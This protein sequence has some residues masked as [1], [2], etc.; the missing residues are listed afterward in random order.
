MQKGAHWGCS[1]MIQ[2]PPFLRPQKV[3][4]FIAVALLVA[5]V[6]LAVIKPTLQTPPYSPP[7]DDSVVVLKA[8]MKSGELYVLS[9]TWRLV[10]A[11]DTLRGSG[12]HYSAT[13]V[14]ID[15]GMFTV[16]V[17]SI[18]V[19]ETNARGA[20]YPFGLQMLAAWT[21]LY[22]IVDVACLADPKSCFGSC[23][24][25]Y[26][27]ESH[28]STPR[29]EG[30]S[31][32]FARA[33]EAT[34]V[35]AL[36]EARPGASQVGITMR[37]EALET[38][39]VRA[40]RLRAALR[41]P[42]G[43]VLAT[44]DGRLYNVLAVA[45]PVACRASEGDCLSAVAAIDRRERLSVADST[46][47]AAKETVELVFPPS[48]GSLGVVI[49]ARNS[50]LSTYVFYQT[51]AY[52]GGRAGEWFARLERAGRRHGAA[53]ALG[54]ER[55][56]GGIEV[57][58]SQGD[59]AWR[60]IGTFHETGPIAGDLQVLPFRAGRADEPVHLRLRLARGNWRLDYVG[61]AH[62]G[63]A[64]TVATLE[65]AR[66]EEGGRENSAALAALLDPDRTLVTGPGDVY[67]LFFDLPSGRGE[68]ELFLESR[69]YYYEWMRKGWLKEENPAMVRLIL[70]KPHRALRQLARQYKAREQVMEDLFWRSRF[71]R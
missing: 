35:D 47:L 28:D 17:D 9:S 59:G 61:L 25:F 39:V 45:A 71:S 33:L 53:L 40:V 13:R 60:T 26:V 44:P 69:G 20:A 56:L 12:R 55:A 66:V 36:R 48:T 68:Y 52:M 49:A 15:S 51:L 3:V 54:I 29:A 7:P 65:P 46:D 41:P 62:L 16:P 34:D 19:V 23:P 24:T 14:V 1:D 27:A 6:G 70:T 5:C 63:P 10:G 50:L 43:H 21:I 32:S 64:A 18:V 67:H 2:L 58:V 11:G 4:P 8:H 42:G 22:G 30:F 38:H 37:N 31:A 57:D